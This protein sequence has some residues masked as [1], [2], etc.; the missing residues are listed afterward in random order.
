MITKAT[1]RFGELVLLLV[2][3]SAVSILLSACDTRSSKYYYDDDNCAPPVPMGLTS[4]TGD[5]VIWLEWDPIIGVGDLEGYYLYR[6]TDNYNFFYIATVSWDYSDYTDDDV[7]N[8]V[9]YFYGISSFDY[10][11]N[12]SEVSFD[13][14]TVY[15]TPRPEGFDEIIYDFNNPELDHMSGFDLSNE[16]R[17]YY[18]HSR[19]D[20]Y[21]EYDNDPGVRAF[22]IWLGSNGQA[23]QDMG[24]TNDFDEITY[25]PEDGWS[26]FS[27][28]EAIEGHTYVILTDNQNYSKV[29]ITYLDSTNPRRMIFDWGYQIDQGNR[30]LKVG[31]P[32]QFNIIRSDQQ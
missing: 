1:N 27:F 26:N 3:I 32:G 24:Y 15:D 14:R 20:F 16:E 8:G 18:D 2:I 17:L 29:R 11:G 9:T 25:A 31:V 28:V 5:G 22:F 7:A 4:I 21:L 6:S 12:E 13:Y 23:I 19:T 10:N 30:E